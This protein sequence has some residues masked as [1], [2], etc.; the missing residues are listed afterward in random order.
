MAKVNQDQSQLNVQTIEHGPLRWVNV[1]KPSLAEMEY[2]KQN[3]SFHQLA[4]DD[5]LS[6]VQL[7][8]VDEYEGYLF[9]VLHFPLFN[10]EARL[11]IPSQVSIFAGADYV[12]TVHK[13]DLRPLTKLFHDCSNSE[14]VRK[15]MMGRSSGYLL[16]RI[17]DGL[18]DS[19]FPILNKVIS[20][21]D[22]LEVRIFDI[23]ARQ[24]VRELSIVRRDIIS[25]RRIVR[26]QIEAL[27]HLEREE[28]PFLKV[29]PD[30]YF[31]DLA[32]H[33]RRIRVELED[34]REVMEGL[35]DTH[36]SLTTHH[37]NDVMRILT[38]LAT[39]LLPFLIGSSLYG[40][41]V[42]LP[43]GDSPLAFTILLLIWAGLAGGLLLFFRLERWL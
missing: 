41:N 6:R 7:P 11:T 26:P 17:L 21:V 13:A 29:N 28:Y 14:L 36:R 42:P 34:L 31:G 38:V 19:C 5:C 40:M 10:P 23:T 39:V 27:E 35:W 2:L 32:D 12:V 37:T 18:V 15:E 22:D 20:N 8:K 30:V 9:V 3:F 25:Y 24:L 16:Y 33:M 4:L 43:L 1:E